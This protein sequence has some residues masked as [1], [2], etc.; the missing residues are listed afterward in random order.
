MDTSISDSLK[1]MYETEF[2][3]RFTEGKALSLE[4]KRFLE[5]MNTGV[6]KVAGHYEAPVPFRNDN[7][8]LPN[9]K[10]YIGCS[11]RNLRCKEM[12]PTG[13]NTLR[14]WTS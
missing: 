4:D 11:P 13:R 5:I 12:S 8:S 7:V 3:E 10:H 2:S 14:R 6:K 1:A 9:N